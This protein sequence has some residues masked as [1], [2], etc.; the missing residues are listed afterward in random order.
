MRIIIVGA[1]IGGMVAAEKL[2]KLGFQVTVY[3]KSPSI[4]EMRFDWHDD[5][6]PKIFKRLGYEIPEEHFN[7][8]SW[9]FCSPVEHTVT[10]FQQ[11]ETDP[12]LSI[13]RRPLNL[14]LYNRAKD[15]A[16]FVF[17]AN[18]TAP[19][20]AGGK[21]AGVVVDGRQEFC[22]LVVDSA[23]VYS[24]VRTNL[25]SD[26][27][28]T[29]IEENEVFEAY[30]AFYRRAENSP[31]PKYTNKVYM[32]HLGEAG[33]SW[34]ILDNDPELVNVLIGRV[35]KLDDESKARALADLKQDN[36]IIGDEIVRGGFNVIIP[37]RYPATRMVADGYVAIGDAAYM[38][39]PLLGSGIASSMLAGDILA[40]TIGRNMSKGIKKEALF[41]IQRL[42]RYQVRVF[43]EFGALH[44]GVDVLKRWMLNLSDETVQWLFTSGVLSNDDIRCVASGKLVKISLCD[45]IQKVKAVGLSKLNTL[46]KLNNLI[47]RCYRA[48]RIG[49]NIPRNFNENTVKGW[50]RRLKRVYKVK[51]AKADK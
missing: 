42:W 4:E 31:T 50:E 29:E 15:N 47:S 37:V 12:D 43:R 8:K 34:A 2:G 22:D 3:E 13:E 49:R 17:G 44:A 7:K 51:R 20:I 5:V 19:L 38:T 45:A 30:R 18:V 25:P 40:E 46:I 33:I 35:G 21:V 36:E 41:S 6:S 23:G 26:F 16:E 28:V 9:T 32:K 48:E 27:D 10:E 11:D 24:P 39:I 1:G 14:M